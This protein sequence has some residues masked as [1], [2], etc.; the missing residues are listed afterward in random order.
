MIIVEGNDE[1]TIQLYIPAEER[2]K[3]CVTTLL[4]MYIGP[5]KVPNTCIDYS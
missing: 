1:A 5:G 2:Y 3:K 4:M